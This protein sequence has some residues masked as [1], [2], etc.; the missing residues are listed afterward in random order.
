MEMKNSLNELKT[1]ID[2]V[3]DIVNE[4]EQLKSNADNNEELKT[5]LE[6]LKV[7]NENMTKQLENLKVE[8]ENMTK[9]LEEID[10]QLGEIL[11]TLNNIL[12]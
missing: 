9:Q 12:K 2:S 6:N 5:Q 8:N 10:N 3:V 11:E 1:L 7:E 4:Y